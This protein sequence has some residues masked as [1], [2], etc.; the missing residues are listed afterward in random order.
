MRLVA[1]RVSVGDDLQ[2]ASVGLVGRLDDLSRR[3]VLELRESSDVLGVVPQTSHSKSESTANTSPKVHAR[4]QQ[5]D[6]PAGGLDGAAS[7]HHR[8]KVD[9]V[10]KEL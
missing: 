10:T 6:D 8:S 2:N 4:R 9:V 7:H 5:P 3:R 1:E